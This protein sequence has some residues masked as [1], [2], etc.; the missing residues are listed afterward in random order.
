MQYQATVTLIPFPE[1]FGP[2]G[3]DSA[4]RID[5]SAMRRDAAKRRRVFGSANLVK[6]ITVRAGLK[7][8]P[9]LS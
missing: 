8:S 1:A 9:T 7:A 6:D 3:D 4:H 5:H 2:A